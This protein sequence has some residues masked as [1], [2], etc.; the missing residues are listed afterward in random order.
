LFVFIE[1]FTIKRETFIKLAL[2]GGGIGF[3]LI[4][5]L[6][7]FIVVFGDARL[8][9]AYLYDDVIVYRAGMGDILY[10]Q[11]EFIAPLK[12]PDE[13]LSVHRLQLDELGF[14]MPAQTAEEYQVV[15]LGD[16]FTEG[17]NVAA[18]WPDVFAQASGLT[19]RNLGFRGYGPVQY[20]YT[21]ENFGEDNNPEVVI[22][23]FFGGNDLATSGLD[24]PNPV[25]PT[26][27]RL[28]DQP[29][30]SDLRRNAEAGASYRYPV[31]LQN[32]EPIA[33]LSTYI[34]WMNLT[35]ETLVQS[36]NYEVIGESLSRIH[37][38]APNACLIFA[39]FPSKAEVYLPYV[40]EQYYPQIIA[41]QQH[42]LIDSDGTLLILD[43]PSISI[44]KLLE[45][46][47]STPNA[48]AGL[49]QENGFAFINL[50]EGFDEEA[51]NREI[52]YYTYDTHWN[53]AGQTL[54][55]ELLANFVEANC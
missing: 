51:A 38:A 24:L 25:L 8:M 1:E 29:L 19:T 12:N 30:N 16:S 18:P 42:V 39:Y 11:G 53:E 37:A 20:A 43:D 41:G 21:M 34:S 48:L 45:N 46:R 47:H 26:E 54:A 55:G 10:W 5:L 15:A 4:L 49:A 31:Y 22:V 33:F 52:L 36:V 28:S 32:G 6:S 50:W 3:A 17:A 9:L 23:G 35:E 40:Q 13:I 7:G 2:I 44:E 27:E 14:R